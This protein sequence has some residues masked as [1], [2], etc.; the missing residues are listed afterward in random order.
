MCKVLQVNRSTYYKHLNKKD[1]QRNIENQDLRT[2]ILTIYS[3]SR[4]RLGAYKIRQWLIALYG[5]KVSVGRVYRL[6]KS[7]TLPKM[8]TSKPVYTYSN[9]HKHNLKNLLNQKFNPKKPNL[10]WVSDI[11]YIKVNNK[12][13]YICVVID[14]FSRKVI[15]YKA[16]INI[17]TKFVLD[18]FYLACSKRGFP[19][20]VMFHSDRGSQYTSKEF[21]QTLDNLDFLQSFSAKAHPFDNAVAE[22]FFKYLKE[23]R[24]IS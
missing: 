21:R 2:N 8:S 24:V 9:T 5:K 3:R 23:G 10:I 7:M 20:G 18:T 22:S 19:K 15:S 13:A 11:T 16:S 1:S 17:D 6:M 14:L 4:K 12:F